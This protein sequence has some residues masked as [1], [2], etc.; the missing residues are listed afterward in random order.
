M[1][2]SM[3]KRIPFDINEDVDDFLPGTQVVND[4]ED[5]NVMVDLFS[6]HNTLEEYMK[7]LNETFKK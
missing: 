3:K 1:A 4:Y 2:T 6:R 5:G 7:L